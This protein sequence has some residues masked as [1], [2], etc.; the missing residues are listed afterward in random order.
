MSDPTHQIIIF[1]Y[2]VLL[3]CYTM[4]SDSDHEDLDSGNSEYQ[5]STPKGLH[6][7]V[8]ATAAGTLEG[9]KHRCTS[10]KICAEEPSYGSCLSNQWS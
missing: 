2:C 5:F 4:T 9:P 1:V 10:Q 3:L 7:N 8:Y 6:Y